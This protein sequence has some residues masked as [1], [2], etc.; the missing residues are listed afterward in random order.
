MKLFLVLPSAIGT[1]ANPKRE[2]NNGDKEKN[3]KKNVDIED[4]ENANKDISP[5]NGQKK[6]KGTNSQNQLSHYNGG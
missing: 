4:D 3:P 6:A 1:K 5:T 2:N